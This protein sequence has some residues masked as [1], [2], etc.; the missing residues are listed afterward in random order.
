MSIECGECGRLRWGTR[1]AR[2]AKARPQGRCAHSRNRQGQAMTDSSKAAPVR[3]NVVA[4]LDDLAKFRD[5]WYVDFKGACVEPQYSALTDLIYRL[6]AA[7]NDRTS[8][9]VT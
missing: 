6:T 9:R 4:I 2:H 8:G 1:N 5:G 3:A 7:E